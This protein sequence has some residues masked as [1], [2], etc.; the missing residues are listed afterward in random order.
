MLLELLPA[1]RRSLGIPVVLISDGQLGYGLFAT[2]MHDSVTTLSSMIPFV[3]SE[4]PLEDMA[5]KQLQ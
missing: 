4:V 3:V 2:A 1:A 5:I